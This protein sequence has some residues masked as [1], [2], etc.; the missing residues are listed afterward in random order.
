[1]GYICDIW[2]YMRY[3]YIYTY[4]ESQKHKQFWSLLEKTVMIIFVWYFFPVMT[5]KMLKSKEH[6]SPTR[7]KTVF[8]RYFVEQKM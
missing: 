4:L 8:L 1:M 2:L 5:P 6:R 3:I 7:S